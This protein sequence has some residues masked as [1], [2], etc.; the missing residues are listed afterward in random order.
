MTDRIC[1]RTMLPNLA[2][3]IDNMKSPRTFHQ[4]YDLHVRE[5]CCPVWPCLK[6]CSSGKEIEDQNQPVWR[7]IHIH[8]CALRGS[9]PSPALGTRRRPWH[10]WEIWLHMNETNFPIL[11]YWQ[12]QK[13]FKIE[14]FLKFSFVSCI[15]SLNFPA[16][17]MQVSFTVALCKKSVYLLTS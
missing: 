12:L 9:L 17:Y 16:V 5:Q 15:S 7:N 3:S 6:H 11:Y 14:K 2:T 10:L 4:H 8:R 1:W 13:F